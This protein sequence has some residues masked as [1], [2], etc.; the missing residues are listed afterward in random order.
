MQYYL[1]ASSIKDFI[2]C[3]KRYEFRMNKAEESEDSQE[4]LVGTVVHKV[5]EDHWDKPKLHN[6][7]LGLRRAEELSLRDD[8]ISRI[9]YSINSFHENFQHLLS[10]KDEAE[11][12]FKL[13]LDTDVF[14]V[15]RIDRILKPSNVIFDWKTS[16]GEVSSIDND[17]QFLIY[18]YAYTR[19]YNHPPSMVSYVS[20]LHNKLINL[21]LQ[22]SK[23]QHLIK[24]VLPGITKQ[25]KDGNFY[26]DGI[27]RGKCFR[28]QFKGVCLT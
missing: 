13:P 20:L 1:S 7:Q 14:L 23:Y 25:V 27:Y 5:L 19:L 3:S 28:C 9:Q 18:Y 16:Q 24:D 26:R 17:V 11:V 15:G 6:L 4:M 12:N 2:D 21:N 22:N 8:M 10:D